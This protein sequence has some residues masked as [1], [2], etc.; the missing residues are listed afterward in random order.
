MSATRLYLVRHGRAS[1]GW[2]TSIDPELDALG[3]EQSIQLAQHL[4]P[5]GPM[6]VVSSPLTRCQQTAGPLCKAW[7][8][9]AQ[10]CHEVAEIPSPEGV[11]ISERVEWLRSAMSGTWESLG[12][13]YTKFRDDLVNFVRQITQDTVV[14]SHFV[15]INAIIGSI[16][17][18]DRLVIHR[19]DNC[20]VTIVERHTD[21]KL[22]LVEVG[23]EADTLIR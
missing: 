2:D 12:S 7:N 6:Q 17:S 19:L 20:S 4:A 8:S 16:E 9:T 14:V 13:R 10:I 18:S 3:R 22:K 21:G 23:R 11:P 1:A 5:L 15:A